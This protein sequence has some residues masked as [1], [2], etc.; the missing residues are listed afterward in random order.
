M[1]RHQSRH[2][3]YSALMI[4]QWST[5]MYISFIHLSKC[6]HYALLHYFAD[7]LNTCI[8]FTLWIYNCSLHALQTGLLCYSQNCRLRRYCTNSKWETFLTN[9]VELDLKRIMVNK[10][11]S[12]NYRKQEAKIN[13]YINHGAAI[14]S[15]FWDIKSCLYRD[16]L[17]FFIFK[18]EKFWLEDFVSKIVLVNSVG[19]KKQYHWLISIM[20]QYKTIIMLWQY[21][22]VCYLNLIKMQTSSGPLWIFLN[23]GIT[24]I[25]IYLFFCY[26]KGQYPGSLQY[27][28]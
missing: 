6:T 26:W 4:S 5:S 9:L 23:S 24:Y 11:R 12:H 18:M 14:I 21:M 19:M 3:D 16:H 10:I 20:F 17:P 13:N 15:C 27:D 8:V 7:F 22:Q 1:T 28:V 25:Y 2:S